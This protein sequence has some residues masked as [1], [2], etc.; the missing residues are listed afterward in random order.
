MNRFDFG[1]GQPLDAKKGHR[2]TGSHGYKL[3]RGPAK[4]SIRLDF[5]FFILDKKN[6]KTYLIR[7]PENLII[8]SIIHFYLNR[9]KYT[10][11]CNEI[12]SPQ[13]VIEPEFSG[14]IEIAIC[15]KK[16]IGRYHSNLKSYSFKKQFLIIKNG[17]F[18]IYDMKLKDNINL[19]EYEVRQEAQL[20]IL[21]QTNPY[22]FTLEKLDSRKLREMNFHMMRESLIEEVEEH[23]GDSYR[24]NKGL[25]GLRSPNPEYHE[26]AVVEEK[27][28]KGF[29]QGIFS[30]LLG[31]AGKKKKREERITLACDTEMKRRQWILTLNYFIM[32]Y[33][34]MYAHPKPGQT[35]KRENATN[36]YEEST[37]MN[38]LQ[39]DTVGNDHA[40]KRKKKN[41][42]S[43]SL[44]N[45]PQENPDFYDVFSKEA[46]HFESEADNRTNNLQPGMIQLN[47]QLQYNPKAVQNTDTV[48]SKSKKAMPTQQDKS[49]L[50]LMTEPDANNPLGKAFL[51]QIFL[52]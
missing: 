22:V 25:G 51:K 7:S 48:N 18:N 1:Q 8:G 27:K 32:Q 37:G 29:L 12:F 5:C 33:I 36:M 23:P 41:K 46:G 38:Y 14:V 42:P 31:G 15:K 44:R 34:K 50:P 16:N 47:S 17:K 20:D 24:P 4:E 19:W 10:N 9:D 52:F 3:E 21:P 6:Q 28:S 26:L 45:G 30:G 2:R 11:L 13:F 43:L 49:N 40:D 39:V 35:S